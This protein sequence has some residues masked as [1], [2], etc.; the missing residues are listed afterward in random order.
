MAESRCVRCGGFLEP[1]S[2]HTCRYCG[3]AQPL[4]NGCVALTDDGVL[5][6]LREHVTGLDSTS[7]HPAIPPKKLGGVR[8]VHGVYLPENETV[9]AL[10]D[11]TVFGSA[12][13]GFFI[14]SKRIGFKNQ[15]EGAQF[16]EWANVDPNNVY[17]DGTS[18]AIGPGRIDTL[19]SSSDD[20]LWQWSEAIGAIAR[21][22]RPRRAEEEQEEA[23]G[24]SAWDAM[25]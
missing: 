11:G 14:T 16:F 5:T 9:L 20:A 6:L 19:Y 12:T 23:G 2:P 25:P 21:S 15:S 3:A 17:V 13:D 1:G 22:A 24:P 4:P 8:K 7:L 10:Y 18:L